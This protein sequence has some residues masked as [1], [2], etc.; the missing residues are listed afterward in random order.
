MDEPSPTRVTGTELRRRVALFC[1]NFLP[2]S[3]VFVYEQL[4]QYRRTDVDVFA[5]RR[6]NPDRF[7]FPRVH[8]AEPSYVIRGRSRVFERAFAAARYDLVHAHFGPAGAYAERYA[9]RG[10]LPLVVTFHGYDVPLLSS[11]R[12][13]LP[14]HLPYALGCRRM[15]QTMR[16]GLCASLELQQMLMDLGVEKE[17]LRVHRLGIDLDRFRV[18]SELAAGR[19][20]MV[21]RLVEKKGFEYGIR[22]FAHALSLGASADLCIVGE[23]PRRAALERLARRLGIERR[24]ELLGSRSNQ[25]VAE[26][27]ATARVLLAPSVVAAD[28]N[29]E[30][31]LIVVKEASAAGAVSIGTLHGGIPESIEDSVTGFLVPERDWMAMGERLARLLADEALHARMA[32]AARDKMEREFDNRVQVARLE[33]IYE[34]VCGGAAGAP[35]LR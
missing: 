28:G 32:R 7:P 20:M 21:G 5:W 18:S 10:G 22:A 33:D 30:S 2:T 19:V 26:M 31:G 9:R 23:G 15:L 6:F 12:R 24:V 25:Q 29:R 4:R 34:E 8:L 16:L 35:P 17:R 13:F 27:L 3:Q 14:L 11:R 1:T